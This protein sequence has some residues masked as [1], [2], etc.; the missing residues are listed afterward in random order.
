LAIWRASGVANPV[1]KGLILA[2][3]LSRTLFALLRAIARPI[4]GTP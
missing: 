2:F 4:H 1:E 3:R